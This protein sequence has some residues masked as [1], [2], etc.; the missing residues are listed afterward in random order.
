PGVPGVG[1][2][3]ALA[4]IQGLGSMDD[5]YANL[6]KVPTLEF[7]G[8]K[9]MPE[10]LAEHEAQARLS[11]QLATIKTDCE[12]KE[13]LADLQLG[14]PDRDALIEHYRS[15]EFKGWLEEVLSGEKPEEA[16]GSND[17]GA[18]ADPPPGELDRSG[19]ELVLT[20]QDFDRWLK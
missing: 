20:Q 15:L 11:Y 7:R 13:S 16:S 2:K 19:Y 8:A 3:T 6:D 10:K 17:D 4:L 14:E 5:I 18:P 9:K 1:D 12:L